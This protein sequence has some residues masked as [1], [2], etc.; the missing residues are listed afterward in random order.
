MNLGIGK[1]A[2]VYAGISM[3]TCVTVALIW[4]YVQ[5][6]TKDIYNVQQGWVAYEREATQRTVLMSELHSVIGYGGF[7]HNFKNYILRGSDIYLNRL[8]R[9]RERIIGTI[10]HFR[11]LRLTDKEVTAIDHVETTFKNYFDKFEIVK[12]EVGKGHAPE[13]IDTMVKV[14][15][16]AALQALDA[17]THVVIEKGIYYRQATGAAIVNTVRTV[18]YSM[19]VIPLLIVSS[20]LFAAVYRRSQKAQTEAIHAKEQLNAILEADPDVIIVSDEQGRITLANR[21][22]EK[23][24]G[25]S[26]D[27]VLGRTIEDL[28]PSHHQEDHPNFRKGFFSGKRRRSAG[29]ASN[30]TARRKNGSEVPV[31]I[32]LGTFKIEEAPYAI[33][34]IRDMTK[35]REIE[36]QLREAKNKAETLARA[37][38][39]LL[40]NMSHE[41]RTPLNAIIGF[42]EVLLTKTF[43]PFSNDKHEEYVTH[44]HSSGEHLLN[45]INDILDMSKVDAGKLDLMVEDVN[46]TDVVEICFNMMKP[47]ARDAGVRMVNI[48]AGQHI[49][50]RVD[51]TRMTQ[52]LLNLLSNAVKFT[53]TD[54]TVS[55]HARILDDGSCALTIIDKGIGMNDEAVQIALEPFGQV[56]SV[57]NRKLDGTG[58]GLPLTKALAELHGGTLELESVE[59]EGTSATIYM[60]ADRVL[61]TGPI[62]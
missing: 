15:D 5:S 39:D 46:L 25:Y 50:L 8:E 6:T 58:L 49:V 14:D 26:P 45:L 28:I 3:V 19:A 16:S 20:F 42:S 22:I 29:D 59:G 41:L 55:A 62:N 47:R 43:G 51:R 1:S 30:I 21:E 61:S 54:G 31:D 2:I 37:K 36:A 24:L 4:F 23:L 44:V 10:T 32:A 18:Q 27:E 12:A 9:D 60:P 17:L 56:D 57:L 11:A 38:S 34:S 40:A 52:M 7:V 48:I 13:N 35:Q 53:D 33:A